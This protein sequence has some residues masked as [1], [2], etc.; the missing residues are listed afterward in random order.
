M[1]SFTYRV[2]ENAKTVAQMYQVVGHHA[3]GISITQFVTGVINKGKKEQLR[4]V[5]CVEKPSEVHRES[6]VDNVLNAIKSFITNVTKLQGLM[7]VITS[8]RI[9][10]D[11]I[12]IFMMKIL[13]CPASWYVRNV[14]IVIRDLLILNLLSLWGRLCQFLGRSCCFRSEHYLFLLLSNKVLC[15]SRLWGQLY[16]LAPPQVSTTAFSYSI[17]FKFS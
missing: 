3:A 14:F 7:Q 15:S 6:T 16:P 4:V 9:V 12:F 2:A 5:P 13:K 17:L 11:M 8:V 1:L 10:E